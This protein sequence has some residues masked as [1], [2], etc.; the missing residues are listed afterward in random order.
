MFNSRLVFLIVCVFIAVVVLEGLPF[1]IQVGIA[2]GKYIEVSDSLV[3][4]HSRAKK[5]D[6]DNTD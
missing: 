5:M 2:S 6:A 1:L 4:F 3:A